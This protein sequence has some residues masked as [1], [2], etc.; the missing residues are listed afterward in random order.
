MAEY[1]ETT[2]DDDAIAIIDTWVQALQASQLQ[3]PG[4]PG[5]VPAF[6]DALL[7]VIKETWVCQASRGASL[8]TSSKGRKPAQN[9]HD[10]AKHVLRMILLAIEAVM[11]DAVSGLPFR[12]LS[13]W[14]PDKGNHAAAID[15]SWSTD[16][17]Q[18]K[19][20]CSALVWHRWPCRVAVGDA[21]AIK[22]VA[23]ADDCGVWEQFL[24]YEASQTGA[25][26]DVPPGPHLLM[27]SLVQ[28][29]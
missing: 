12:R 1:S 27:E 19:F 8:G 14:C 2:S 9:G 13:D 6:A 5:D 11:P 22:D 29:T 28:R 26:S 4:K 21:E 7:N 15:K 24:A 23:T 16:M 10:N 18:E 20:G 3:W 17:V 25:D